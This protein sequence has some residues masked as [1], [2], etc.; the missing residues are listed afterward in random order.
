MCLRPHGQSEN[1][2][3]VRNRFEVIYIYI[4]IYTVYIYIYIYIYIMYIRS[5]SFYFPFLHT[6][7]LFSWVTNNIW[8]ERQWVY[9][10]AWTRL[11]CF[12]VL[13]PKTGWKTKIFFKNI[14]YLRDHLFGIVVCT[15]DCHPRGS[16]FDSRLYS[17]NFSR[18]I[19]SGTGST[20]PPEDNWVVNWYDK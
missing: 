16:G 8:N 7:L 9:A 1:F 6:L 3:G 18:S 20:Q 15:S 4:Y 19:G 12:S 11:I 13:L 10:H 17:R 14:Q 5:W 2:Y